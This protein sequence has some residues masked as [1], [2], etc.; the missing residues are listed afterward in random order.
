MDSYNFSVI[1]LFLNP[2]IIETVVLLSTGNPS[3]MSGQSGR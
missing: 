1:D 3:D 2:Q